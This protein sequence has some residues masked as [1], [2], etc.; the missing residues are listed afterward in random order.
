MIICILLIFFMITIN[1]GQVAIM[2]TDVSNAADAAALAIASSVTSGLLGLGMTSDTMMGYG[3]LVA[4][5]MIVA[6][7][8]NDWPKNLIYALELYVIGMISQMFSFF[9]SLD[10]SVKMWTGAK[11]KGVSYAFNNL[12][13][14]EPKPSFRQ[15]VSSAC[16]VTFD[17]LSVDPTV[18]FTCSPSI[19]H[20]SSLPATFS[21]TLSDLYKD[22]TQ[23]NVD[24]TTRMALCNYYS[25]NGFNKFMEDDKGGYWRNSED[26]KCGSH[27]YACGMA[28]EKQPSQTTGS[29][30]ISG[31][32][33][34]QNADKTFSGSYVENP[35]TTGSNNDYHN[36]FKNYAEVQIEAPPFTTSLTTLGLAEIGWLGK[37]IAIIF[38][39]LVFIFV[40][41][42]MLE[43]PAFEVWY[44][45]IVAVILALVIAAI[46]T[47]LVWELPVGLK[48]KEKA[49]TDANP[50]T[51]KVNRY[52][53]PEDLGLWRFWYGPKSSPVSAV[54]V[55]HIIRPKIVTDS[56]GKEIDAA[57]TTIQP[58]LSYHPA[59]KIAHLIVALFTKAIYT[60]GGDPGRNAD[61]FE[62]FDA[63]RH[64]YEA[65]LMEVM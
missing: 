4:C 47:I 15:Y 37:T 65:E 19:P 44:M 63:T 51:V 5:Y 25:R 20:A 29:R 1:L 56:N 61:V 18:P 40:L 62:D 31:Y 39:I 17:N 52:K 58:T 33:W 36:N 24:D 6:M 53:A 57:G 48:M 3:L 32:G 50:I 23:G 14:D 42:K 22:Y 55:S 43:N 9:T 16:R 2:R 13:V 28:D 64:L 49:E 54:S 35:G 60:L 27:N 11:K 59:E 46:S 7:V 8:Q 10:S 41:V 30:L 12:G 34:T 38:G 45:V 21:T 26:P